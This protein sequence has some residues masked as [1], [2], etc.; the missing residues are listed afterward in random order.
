[1]K[2]NFNII[3]NELVAIAE[4][5]TEVVTSPEA[6]EVQ[7]VADALEDGSIQGG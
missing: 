3:R 6:Q 4:R 2:P 1:M 7:R 5:I